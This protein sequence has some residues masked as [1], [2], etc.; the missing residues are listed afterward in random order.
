MGLDTSVWGRATTR[1]GSATVLDGYAVG[2]A[3][4]Y[5]GWAVLGVVLL[6]LF[7]LI[8]SGRLL[9][10][11]EG[12]AMQNRI[13]KQDEALDL[14]DETIARFTSGVELNNDLVRAFLHVARSGPR[15]GEKL[16]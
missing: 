10:K 8:T 1:G 11:R 4:I 5:G 13:E 9:T 2:E 15:S 12:D 3:A 14:K 7:R 16:P 6:T